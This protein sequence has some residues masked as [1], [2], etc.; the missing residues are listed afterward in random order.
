MSLYPIP[1]PAFQDNY[2]WCLASAGRALV[3]DPGDAEVVERWLQEQGLTL[4]IILITHHHADHIGG[5]AVLKQRHSPVVY[6]PDEAIPGLD[7][8]L[9]G[10]ETLALRNFGEVR[11]LGV[12]G[13]TRSHI[14]YH[15]SGS[16]LLFC[17][18]TLFSAGCGRLFEGTA[19]QM[20][21]SLQALAA[22]PDST[23]VCCAHEYTLAN[24][25]FAAVIEPDNKDRSLREVQAREMRNL[26]RPTLPVRL[27]DER[28]YNPFLRCSEPAVIQAARTESGRPLSA[29]LEVFTAL[30]R[31]K[32][33]F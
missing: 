16:E 23:L 7:H 8:V 11:V 15:L 10:G 25:R 12:P 1:L 22:L 3:V 28:R 18:D 26:A 24:L 27:A 4:A 31:W 5:L 32:D 29:G 13:H 9:R 20:Y 19:A 33:N 30:R 14:A 17:G 21:A 6:G 2:I